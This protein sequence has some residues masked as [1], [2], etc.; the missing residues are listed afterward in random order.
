MRDWLIV[1]P[2]MDGDVQLGLAFCTGIFAYRVGDEK[3]PYLVAHSGPTQF[4]GIHPELATKIALD[5]REF[6]RSP[7]NDERI[8]LTEIL[9]IYKGSLITENQDTNPEIGVYLASGRRVGGNVTDLIFTRHFML[10][11]ILHG[12]ELNK[13]ARVRLNPAD[14]KIS[15][16]RLSEEIEINPSYLIGQRYEIN[17][18]L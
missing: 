5:S 3:S 8:S 16:F 1:P 12:A 2:D 13:M 4:G 10:E 18:H 17:A 7:D 11:G 9:D 6:N 14:R 15:F